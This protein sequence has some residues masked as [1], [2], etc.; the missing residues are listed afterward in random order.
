MQWETPFKDG[1]AIRA[2]VT[3]K[4]DKAN[5]IAKIYYENGK[6]E[7]EATLVDGKK[8]GIAKI[9]YENGNLKSE[10]CYEDDFE[11]WRED[12]PDFSSD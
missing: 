7:Q 1:K 8:N 11:V 4:D 6:I 10:I 12:Y 9:Y 5:G 3:Y 2:E